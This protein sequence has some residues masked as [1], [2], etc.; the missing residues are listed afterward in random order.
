MTLNNEGWSEALLYYW[1]RID[2][3]LSVPK[4]DKEKRLF[5]F[6]I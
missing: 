6:R 4:S 5:L 1:D 2:S 3:L